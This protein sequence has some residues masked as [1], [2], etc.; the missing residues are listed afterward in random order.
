M[1]FLYNSKVPLY[2]VQQLEWSFRQYCCVFFVVTLILLYYL[3]RPSKVDADLPGPSRNA[4]IGATFEAEAQLFDNKEDFW[5]SWPK[6]SLILCRKFNFRTWGAP[7]LNIG[8]GGSFF[9]ICSPNELK[10]VLQDNFDNYIKGKVARKCLKEALGRGIFTADSQLWKYHRKFVVALMNKQLV[11]IGMERMFK[12]LE[13]VTKLLDSLS[14]DNDTGSIDFQDLCFRMILD[15]F[16]SIAFGINLDGVLNPDKHRTFITAF[17]ELQ[18]LCHQRFIDIFWEVKQFFRIGQREKRIVECATI[19]DDFANKMIHQIRKKNENNI[20]GE[21]VISRYLRYNNNNDVPTNNKELRDVVMNFILAGRDSTACALSWTMYELTRHP[22]WANKIREEAAL[23]FGDDNKNDYNVHQIGKLKITHAVVMEAL[24]LHPPVPEDF[25]FA[26]KQDVLPDGTNIPA[27]ACVMY[28][29]F[30]INRNHNIWGTTNTDVEADSNR[31]ATVAE[32]SVDDFFPER[33]LEASF[34]PTA[35]T[36]P[37][38]NAGPRICPG[39]NLAVTE[40]KMALAYLLQRYEFE[41]TD[42]HDGQYLFTLVMRMKGGFPLQVKKR[43][44]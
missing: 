31:N 11:E 18:Y 17:N 39:K 24:R 23:I 15:V 4:I 41:D 21:D 20:N 44:K 22:Q 37:T 9:V 5:S 28:S 35:F 29:P 25:K 33:F 13:E 2:V 12:K 3:F 42:C 30:S 19:I 16:A 38:F 27:G 7:T 1:E 36:F 43:K 32:Y 34:V 6:F 10:H 14:D 40:I 26:V 8:F